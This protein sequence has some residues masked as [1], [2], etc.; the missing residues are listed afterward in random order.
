LLPQTDSVRLEGNTALG[1]CEALLI[2]EQAE[3]ELADI[4]AVSRIYNL[5]ED[6]GFEMLFVE[7]LYLQTIPQAGKEKE[8]DVR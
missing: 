4:L 1:G 2:S 5:A 6:A 7:N 8:H 3:A